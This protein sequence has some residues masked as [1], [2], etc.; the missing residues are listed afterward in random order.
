VAVC[1]LYVQRPE[2]GRDLYSGGTGFLVGRNYLVT[3]AHCLF[4]KAQGDVRRI[5]V[6]PAY[7]HGV[8]VH[9]RAAAT[10]WWIHPAYRHDED[11]RF[12]IA[13]V[14]LDRDIGV[15]TGWFSLAAQPARRLRGQQVTSV[16]FPDDCDRGER[17]VRVAGTIRD[18]AENRL[19]YDFYGYPGQSGSPV[20]LR[21]STRDHAGTVI[22]LDTHGGRSGASGTRITEAILREFRRFMADS[23]T[24]A[25]PQSER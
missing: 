23:T 15:Q 25:T 24:N 12:D 22:G 3:A 11:I 14:R 10:A 4:N 13:I 9:G 20:F 17:P 1:K 7:V 18:I 16:G 2:Y 6:V 21:D 8:E 5:E 19:E